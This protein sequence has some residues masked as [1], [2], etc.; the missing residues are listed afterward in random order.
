MLLCHGNWLASACVSKKGERKRKR[1]REREKE[2]EDADRHEEQAI[3]KDTG[4]C[5]WKSSAERRRA[6]PVYVY[7]NHHQ[8]PRRTDEKQPEYLTMCD[9]LT[10][11]SVSGVYMRLWVSLFYW[12]DEKGDTHTY[13]EIE[14][15]RE[16]EREDLWTLSNRITKG[17]AA[18]DRM[19]RAT[20]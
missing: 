13:R 12:R 18:G 2:K 7:N 11:S 9:P 14:K 1:E 20:R 6:K 15:E 4:C 5:K 10:D 17:P 19:T 3:I 8:Q 16:R